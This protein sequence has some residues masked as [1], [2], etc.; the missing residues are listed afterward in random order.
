MKKLITTAITD[1]IGM[2]VKSGTLDHIQAAYQEAISES[3]KACIGSGYNSGVAYILNGLVNSATHPSYN[4][5]AG[6]IFF[7]GEVYLV[8]AANFTLTGGQTAVLVLNEAFTPAPNADPVEF[9]DGIVRNIHLVRKAVLTPTAAGSGIANYPDCQRINSNLPFVT[10]TAGAGISIAGGFPNFTINNTYPPSVNPIL[11]TRKIFLGDL[12]TDPTDGYTTR[13][14]GSTNALTAYLH[15]FPTPLDDA[16]YT[17]VFTIGNQGDTDWGG[18][19]DNYM[20]V[21]TVGY[22][23]ATKM[24]FAVQTSDASHTQAI[25]LW[26][27]LIKNPS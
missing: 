26:Y 3:V 4:T 16:N 11:R 17:P 9:T 22:F 15:N 24:Y 1:Q 8:D 10:L 12:N 25:D 14:S 27:T 13:L 5:N 20:C 18:F 2:P 7:N 6:S 19:N 21:V 23:D